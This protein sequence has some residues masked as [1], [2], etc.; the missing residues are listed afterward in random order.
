MAKRKKDARTN[1]DLQ[2]TKDRATR[3]PLNTGGE[4]WCSRGLIDRKGLP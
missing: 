2:N 1:T 3:T 4:L